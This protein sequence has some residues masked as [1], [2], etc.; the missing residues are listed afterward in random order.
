MN[1]PKNEKSLGL[2][3]EELANKQIL[4]ACDENQEYLRIEKWLSRMGFDTTE[5]LDQVFSRD[6]LLRFLDEFQAKV[7]PPEKKQFNL[8]II[9]HTNY[10]DVFEIMNWLRQK[11][12]AEDAAVLVVSEESQKKMLMA[13]PGKKG[14]NGF[15]A[16][17]LA[18]T[19]FQKEVGDLIKH[20]YDFF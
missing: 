20:Q 13:L 11:Q 3:P 7:N 1:D 18:E 19:R 10:T 12:A 17:P 5:Q 16:R 14:V 8:V 2:L 15:L 4:I 6:D 9:C